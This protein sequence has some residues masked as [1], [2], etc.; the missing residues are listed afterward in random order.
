MQTI[1]RNWDSESVNP[2]PSTVACYAPYLTVTFRSEYGKQFRAFVTVDGRIKTSRMEITNS[3]YL[4]M[5]ACIITFTFK[6]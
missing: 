1:P 4:G 5:N 3:V 2:E 6:F